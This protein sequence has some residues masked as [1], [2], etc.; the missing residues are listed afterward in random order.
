MYAAVTL[1]IATCS[2]V[3]GFPQKRPVCQPLWVLWYSY[4]HDAACL[5]LASYPA[6]LP[7]HFQCGCLSLKVPPK[8]QISWV[9]ELLLFSNYYGVLMVFVDKF[10]VWFVDP[11]FPLALCPIKTPFPGLHE[12]QCFGA[13]RREKGQKGNWVFWSMLWT[14]LKPTARGNKNYYVSF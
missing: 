14:Y 13:V 4:C 8:S 6:P 7:P 12:I 1:L 5:T 9:E 10:T 3:S 11:C 2:L